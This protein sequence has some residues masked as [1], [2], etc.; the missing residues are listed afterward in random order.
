MKSN[1]TA[2]IFGA[3]GLI[4]SEL[5][6]KL[7]H[8]TVYNRV[9][10]YVRTPLKIEHP[11]LE[12]IT[13]AFDL[14]EYS[15][16]PLAQDVFVCVGTT[17]KKAGSQSNFR[18]VDFE[19]PVKVAKAMQTNDSLQ[20]L[21]VISSVGASTLTNN[22]YLKTKGEMENTIL[23]I[24]PKSSVFVQP[25]LLLGRR[26]EFRLGETIG[27]YIFMCLSFLFIGILK[28]YKPIAAATVANAMV[29]I[30]Q[31][32][33]KQTIFSSEDLQILGNV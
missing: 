28:K 20:H 25:S 24:L 2:I 22:F 9:I 16:L 10:S 26:T 21:I 23:T 6:G 18:A 1:K 7:L 14:P 30:A 32:E 4:G 3:S 27:Q 31:N 12:Q 5:L 13:L 33:H 8:S 19:I 11:C 17:I 29:I 15:T